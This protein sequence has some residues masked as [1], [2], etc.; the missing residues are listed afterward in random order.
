MNVTDPVFIFG[1][2]VVTALSGA[3]GYL[4]RAFESAK[5]MIELELKECQ[6]DRIRLWEKSAKLEAR[7]TKNTD[8]METEHEEARRRNT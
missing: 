3:V 7:V 6:T 8:D 2:A 1:G 4:F 5:K